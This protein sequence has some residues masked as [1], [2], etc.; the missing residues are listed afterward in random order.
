MKHIRLVSS[1]DTAGNL[2]CCRTAGPVVSV[3][4]RV[5]VQEPNEAT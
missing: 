2:Q 1:V 4:R 3:V 5:V